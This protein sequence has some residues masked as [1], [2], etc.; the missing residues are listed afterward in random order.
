[1]VQTT[2]RP[3][4][5]RPA[6]HFLLSNSFLC[7][8]AKGNGFTNFVEFREAPEVVPIFLS[9]KF[10]EN[11][12]LDNFISYFRDFRVSRVSICLHATI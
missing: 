9:S 8:Q 2:I 11:N 7:F 12:G 5:P 3:D 10:G 1:M 4:E 6:L